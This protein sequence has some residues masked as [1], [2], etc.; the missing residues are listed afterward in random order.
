MSTA[1]VCAKCQRAITA[2]SVLTALDRKWHRLC[3]VCQKCDMPL[4]NTSFHERDDKAFCAGCWT[5]TFQPKCFVSL[6]F[7]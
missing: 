4:E 2:E 5:A 3:F 1:P 7:L 6:T